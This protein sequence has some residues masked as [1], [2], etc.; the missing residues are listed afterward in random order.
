MKIK[1][2][3]KAFLIFS[4][5][6]FVI[7]LFFSTLNITVNAGDTVNVNDIIGNMPVENNPIN[8]YKS[9]AE[10]KEVLEAIPNVIEFEETEVEAI[11]SV[12]N[13]IDRKIMKIL[14]EK[15]I[16]GYIV[17]AYR[18]ANEIHDYIVKVYES[19]FSFEANPVGE[20]NITVRFSNSSDYKE[21]YGEYIKSKLQDTNAINLIANINLG[22][23]IGSWNEIFQEAENEIIKTIEDESYFTETE[24]RSKK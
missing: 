2:K 6:M 24:T 10:V 8:I 12:L 5:I 11:S 15:E 1:G 13:K 22:E 19:P 21:E 14:E 23:D 9:N 7:S 16:K 17:S 20:K 18:I 3:F 4:T